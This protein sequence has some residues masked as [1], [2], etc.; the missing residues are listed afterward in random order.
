MKIRNRITKG[1]VTDVDYRFQPEG[2]LRASVNGYLKG[3]DGRHL[4]WTPMPGTKLQH[5]FGVNELIVGMTNLQ[6]KI[7]VFT[8]NMNLRI[9]DRIYLVT[10][11][12]NGDVLSVE[13]KYEGIMG[14]TPTTNAIRAKTYFVNDTKQYLYWVDGVNGSRPKGFNI[15]LSGLLSDPANPN[16]I[17]IDTLDFSPNHSNSQIAL[18][19]LG[20]GSLL[21]GVY[22][23]SYQLISKSGSQTDWSPEFGP[24]SVAMG[25][26]GSYQD[27]ADYNA[28]NNDVYTGK[29]VNLLIQDLDATKWSRLRVAAWRAIDKDNVEN[30]YVFHDSLITESG[31]VIV[32]HYGNEALE[33]LPAQMLN[34]VTIEAARDFTFINKMLDF[35]NIQERDELK[36]WQPSANITTEIYNI[37]C[38]ERFR[39]GED[40]WGE[41]NQTIN[42]PIYGTINT[43]SVSNLIYPNVWYYVVSGSITYNG[44]V[45]TEG[46]YFKGVSGTSNMT[47]IQG[48]VTTAIR[49]RTNILNGTS[50]YLSRPLTNENV[51]YKNPFI[52]NMMAGYW[53]DETYRVGILLYDL[54]G[55]P[56]YVRHLSDVIIP[57]RVGTN[58][59]IDGFSVGGSVN[60][61]TKIISLVVDE[62]DITDIKDKI[63]GFSIVV[64]PRDK[65]IKA[66]GALYPIRDLGSEETTRVWPTTGVSG[67]GNTDR[68]KN[69]FAFYSPEYLFEMENYSILKTDKLV[70]NNHLSS[71]TVNNAAMGYGLLE[72]TNYHYYQKYYNSFFSSFGPTN[73][74]STQKQNDIEQAFSVRLNELVYLDNIKSY[75]NIVK[76]EAASDN[77]GG[78]G[79][80]TILIKVKNDNTSDMGTDFSYAQYS[81]EAISYVQIKELK[82]NLYGG[83]NDAALSAT[84]YRLAGHYQKVDANS[85]NVFYSIQVFGGDCFVNLFDLARVVTDDNA[86]TAQY[87]QGIIFPV[88]SEINIAL[89]NGKTLNRCRSRENNVN[90]YTGLTTWSER[91]V[92]EQFNYNYAMSTFHN[93]KLYP[94]LPLYFENDTHKPYRHRYSQTKQFNE[95]YDNM[96]VFLSNDYVDVDA[97]LGEIVACDSEQSRIYAWQKYGLSY[98]AVEER[99]FVVNNLGLPLQLGVGGKFD[100]NDIV[101]DYY[102]AQHTFGVVR[103]ING[104]VWIDTIRME[105]LSLNTNA[106]MA[107]IATELGFLNDLQTLCLTGTESNDNPL[108][109]IIEPSIAGYYDPKTK[110]VFFCNGQQSIGLDIINRLYTGWYDLKV[111]AGCNNKKHLYL[112]KGYSWDLGPVY[113]EIHGFGMGLK[114]IYFNQVKVAYFKIVVIPQMNV[115]GSSGPI[116]SI[117]QNADLY[118]KGILLQDAGIQITCETEYQYLLQSLQNI[119]HEVYNNAVHLSLPEVAE[120]ERLYGTFLVL[121]V[122]STQS[123]RQIEIYDIETTFKKAI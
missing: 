95:K 46:Q 71:V 85:P 76:A 86:V 11:Q 20:L 107:K 108:K 115:N 54:T 18:L 41:S 63:S 99:Q 19:S 1:V 21:N 51:D 87:S 59:L 121:G 78:I 88:Q 94:A 111:S 113:D 50:Q 102:G 22:F 17:H 97:N 82:S 106:G 66:E 81:H 72:T 93:G 57:R 9:K 89:R 26:V 37:P 116:S 67:I 122:M 70:L 10:L 42:G 80:N 47:S 15:A 61:Y 16:Y 118:G 69:W 7:V 77:R 40:L 84:T 24:V 68:L 13:L 27:N 4:L 104:W 30:G 58:D 74:S 114:Q 33:V 110:Y 14:F 53:G 32:N 29:S 75:Q 49:I 38:D 109:A 79:S 123:N 112:A 28:D 35:V 120:Y 55:K 56:M 12:N 98:V 65:Q 36:T 39:I 43:P 105:L 103:T 34:S 44:T 45:Y 83:N 117:F 62:L 90:D 2:T 96:K 8:T 91:P 48:V 64:A 101:Q 100:R 73:L 60:Y 31:N 119:Y 25:S 52:A 92:L 5:A 6:E 23:Y 3:S